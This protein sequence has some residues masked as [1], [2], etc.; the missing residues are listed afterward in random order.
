MKKVSKMRWLT[1]VGG[2]SVHEHHSGDRSRF[3]HHRLRVIRIVAGKAEY[4][5]SGCI[6]TDLGSCRPA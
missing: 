2:Y 3:A 5:G 1:A 4:L 6:R